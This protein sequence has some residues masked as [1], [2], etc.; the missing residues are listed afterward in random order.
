[1]REVIVV[2]MNYSIALG[3]IR[4]LG[5]LGYG[6]RLLAFNRRVEEIA[7]SSK[8]VTKCIQTSFDPEHIRQGLDELRGNENNILVIPLNDRCCRI[9]DEQYE[10]LS[11]HFILPNMNDRPGAVSAFMNKTKQKETA[12]K[13]GMKT[14][15]GG[16]YTTDDDGITSAKDKV[17]YPCFLKPSASANIP[18]SKTALSVCKNEDELIRAMVLSRDKGCGSV[19]IEEYLNVT[20][21]LCIYG[22]AGNDF[23][24]A[25]ALVETI[26]E[27]VAEHRGVAAEGIV[28]S[29]NRIRDIKEKV[30]DLVKSTGLTGLFCVDLLQCGDEIYFSEINLRGGGSEYS[31][32]LA[33]ANLPGTLADMVYKEKCTGPDDIIREVHFLNER[34]ELDAFRNGYL[35]AKDY[36]RHC[37]SPTERFIQ[38]D[39]DPEPWKRFKRYA[40]FCRIIRMIRLIM[41]EFLFQE[42]KKLRAMN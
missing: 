18:N 7:G 6:V 42:L 33:G 24:Y 29:A 15:A 1:M 5:V 14:A 38:S 20:K 23:V 41:P 22:V 39:T 19:L 9:I 31:A 34:I 35:S 26:R 11:E 8:Y 30:E 2:G 3:V 36:Y 16:E 32:T 27:G 12:E 25:P 10:A 37:K 28:R 13:C 21:E 4:S 40:F 17:R